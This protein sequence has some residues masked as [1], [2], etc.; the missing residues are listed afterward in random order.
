MVMSVGFGLMMLLW[1][2]GVERESIGIGGFLVIIGLGMLVNSLF[3]RPRPYPLPPPA[4]PS[5]GPSDTP[6]QS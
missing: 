4:P 1:F 6:F 5:G 2:V 3:S